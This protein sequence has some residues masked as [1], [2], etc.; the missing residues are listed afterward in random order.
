M[1]LYDQR[2]L[3]D[4]YDQQES[5]VL[6]ELT[7]RT[8]SAFF[9]ASLTRFRGHDLEISPAKVFTLRRDKTVQDKL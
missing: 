8:S 2:C 9:F 7:F 3:E 4:N 1:I 6:N 5:I